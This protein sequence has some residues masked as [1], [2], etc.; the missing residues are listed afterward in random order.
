MDAPHISPNFQ[1]ALLPT[2]EKL[3]YVA[4][5]RGQVLL[6]LWGEKRR[7][8]AREGSACPC[9]GE[10]HP[11]DGT[12]PIAMQKTAILGIHRLLH[13]HGGVHNLGIIGV[14]SQKGSAVH[15]NLVS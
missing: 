1:A 9:P 5:V 11:W 13:L 2:V 10:N 12:S 6:T 7:R 15:V 4:Y 8:G 14:L 3:K